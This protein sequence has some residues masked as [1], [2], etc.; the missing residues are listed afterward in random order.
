MALAHTGALAG[1]DAMVDAVIKQYGIARVNSLNE[2]IETLAVMHS[3]KLPKRGG[4][5]AVTNSGGASA[6]LADYAAEFGLDLP[7]FGQASYDIIR[8]VL[9]D[10]ITVSNPLD[11]T[12]PGGVA[13]QHI[14]AAALDA[15]GADP[16]M[17]I[18]LWQLG[19]NARIDAQGPGGK[20]L[21]AAMK[22]YPEK[23][24]LKISGY[25]GTFHDKPLGVPDLI[26]PL[27]DLDGVP[28]SE[29]RR[30]G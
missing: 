7:Q 4:I 24:W 20:V 19:A 6:I 13:D 22:Q 29:E 2:M 5:G 14:H 26:E 25:A 12:G 15:M 9:Y 11:I 21:T 10:Y 1:S 17:E 28:R 18:I 30:V 16:N 3:R 27:S 8:P 23:I